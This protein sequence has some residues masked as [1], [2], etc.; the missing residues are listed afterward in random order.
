MASDRS[1]MLNRS[2]DGFLSDRFIGGVEKFIEFAMSRTRDGDM[3][4]CPCSICKN[5][6]FLIGDDVKFHLYKNGFTRGYT[7][8]N[9]QGKPFSFN[10]PN[11]VESSTAQATTIESHGAMVLDVMGTEMYHD[12]INPNICGHEEQTPNQHAA[13]FFTLLEEANKPIWPVCSRHTNLSIMARLLNLKSEF[14]MPTACYDRMLSIIKEIMP[15]DDRLEATF[16]KTKKMLS[17]LGLGIMKIHTC[18]NDCM[19]YYKEI[20]SMTQ[21]PTC[22]SPRYKEKM[23]R[24]G[25]RIPQ[26]VLRYLPL[27]SRLQ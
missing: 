21:S 16:Y 14:N 8:W 1:W 18:V 26:K 6:R 19:L 13:N 24:S 27:T 22:F 5:T 9:A 23:S 25:H 15:E 12:Y 2:D 7:Q 20:E 3:I 11:L 10:G 17:S 4:K